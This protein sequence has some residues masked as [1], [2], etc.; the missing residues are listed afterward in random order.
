MVIDR[1]ELVTAA[2]LGT[3]R[4]PPTF[5]GEVADL[6]PAQVLLSYAARSAVAQRAGALLPSAPSPPRGPREQPPMAPRAAEELLTRLLGRPVVE[7]LNIWLRAAA[8]RGLSTGPAHW[9]ALVTVAVR[10][11]DLDRTALA[12]VLGPR[13]VWFCGQNPQWQR[14]AS[15]LDQ[16]D[17]PAPA[18][19][20]SSTGG[21]RII[22][23]AAVEA[24]PDLIFEAPDPWPGAL[25]EVAVSIIGS[26]ALRRGGSGYAV[27]V[28]LRLP[29]AQARRV[30]ELTDRLRRDDQQRM[31]F[32]RATRDALTSLERTLELRLEIAQAFTPDHDQQEMS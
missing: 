1:N 9:T 32:D 21:V 29:L 14:L 25:V 3:D 22:N 28:G 18:G 6:E 16:A 30:Q 13:G 7:L 24:D 20:D 26:G 12:R 17:P 27:A 15:V 5:L 4:R 11:T 19:P 2:L 8:E 10:R 31:I 23:A